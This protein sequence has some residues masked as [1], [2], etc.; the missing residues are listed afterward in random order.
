ME[1]G[2]VYLFGNGASLWEAPSPTNERMQWS[3]PSSNIDFGDLE[4]YRCLSRLE[5]TATRCGDAQERTPHA[6]FYAP[7]HN[8]RGYKSGAPPMHLSQ[9]V[10]EIR[11]RGSEVRQN[12]CYT[13]LLTVRKCRFLHDFLIESGAVSLEAKRIRELGV[14]CSFSRHIYPSF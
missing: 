5:S 4:A 2:E 7:T 1:L 3:D 13:T 14:A 6:W 9:L 10:P 8:S 12:I 11:A